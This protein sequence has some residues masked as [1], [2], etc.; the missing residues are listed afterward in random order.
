VGDQPHAGQ[1]ARRRARLQRLRPCRLQQLSTSRRRRRRRSRSHFQR[2]AEAARYPIKTRR[3]SSCFSICRRASTPTGPRQRQSSRK[4]GRQSDPP[5]TAKECRTKKASCSKQFRTTR[6]VN[7][8]VECHPHTVEV[9]GPNPV[10]PTPFEQQSR[11]VRDFTSD[12][13]F[14]FWPFPTTFPTT[15][16]P[17]APYEC[18]RG[19][20]PSPSWC[21]SRPPRPSNSAVASPR[22]RAPILPW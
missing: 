21:A 4:I 20:S 14:S 7:S 22:S 11:P 10:R 9:T 2:P 17:P 6:G 19:R 16:T 8:A 18:R 13:P 5:L 1:Q 3:S 15:I 12:R